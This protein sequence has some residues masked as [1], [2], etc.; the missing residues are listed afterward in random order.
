MTHAHH[1]HDTVE[2]EGTGFAAGMLLAVAVLVLLAV[3]GLALLFTQPWDD[4]GDAG[5]EQPVPGINEGGGDGGT[6]EGGG[7][8]GGG[9]DGGGDSGG[10]G[11]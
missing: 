4:D 11:Q 2:R 10:T 3:V 9:T 7:E 5:I 6:G 8:G 1:G